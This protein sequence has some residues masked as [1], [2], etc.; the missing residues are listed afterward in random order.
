VPFSIPSIYFFFILEE[1]FYLVSNIKVLG[2]FREEPIILGKL[3]HSQISVFK[4]L[5]N[6]TM[7]PGNIEKEEDEKAEQQTTGRR[8]QEPQEESR[9]SLVLILIFSVCRVHVP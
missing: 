7:V 9:F 8:E 4:L 1:T 3:G 2:K 5:C 6:G